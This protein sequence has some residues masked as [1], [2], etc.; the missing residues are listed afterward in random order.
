MADD[1]R[2]L[3]AGVGL[4]LADAVVSLAEDVLAHRRNHGED[5]QV[6]LRLLLLRDV[7]Q[8]FLLQ[9]PLRVEEV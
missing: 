4:E 9:E 3:L 1:L 5:H 6:A 2:G 7:D 8:G